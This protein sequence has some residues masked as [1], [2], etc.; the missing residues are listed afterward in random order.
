MRFSFFLAVQKISENLHIFA[1]E[2]SL[3]FYRIQEHIRKVLP[4]IIER[5]SE[6]L[7]L[8]TDLQGRCYDME[9]A[10]G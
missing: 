3:A 8:Q 5:R 2:P 4:L 10:I 6:V 7:H 9:Y 1:N